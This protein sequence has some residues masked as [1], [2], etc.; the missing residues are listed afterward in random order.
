[1]TMDRANARP[2][3]TSRDLAYQTNDVR[4]GGLM[5]LRAGVLTGTSERRRKQ[6]NLRRRQ[7]VE[8]APQTVGREARAGKLD[9]GEYP[10]RRRRGVLGMAVMA[11][12]T[13]RLVRY[14]GRERSALS[15]YV[16][17]AYGR[18]SAY[19]TEAGLKYYR[20]GVVGSARRLYGCVR[21]YGELGTMERKE[22][23]LRGPLATGLGDRASS[24]DGRGSLRSRGACRGGIW[25]RTS[26]LRIKMGAVPMHRWVADV[27]EGAPSGSGLYFAVMG[28]V[29]MRR[30]LIRLATLW[31]WSDGDGS[32]RGRHPQAPMERICGRTMAVGGRVAMVQYRWKRRLA[33]SG[34]RNVGQ[35]R[36][37]LLV[38]TIDG[39]VGVRVYR[40]IY[41]RMTRM[42]WIARRSLQVSR[43]EVKYRTERTGLG[44]ENARRG[45]TR[46]RRAMSRAGVPPRGGFRG[47]RR[48]YREAV[49]QGYV[50]RALLGV[51]SGVVGAFNYLRMVKVSRFDEKTAGLRTSSLLEADR[52]KEEGMR[53]GTRRVTRRR[54]LLQPMGLRERSRSL[55]GER[56]A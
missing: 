14:R 43:R 18:G 5:R 10:L 4:K 44:Y 52:T 45:G 39:T 7:R 15:M 56:L 55:A 49:E 11:R 35:R 42:A 16:L 51:V 54:R 2:R 40:R 24:H 36:R 37:G 26:A 48:V 23:Q 8:E 20:V 13:D 31:H 53:L 34:I 22:M 38:G 41:R 1:M 28:K 50:R 30:V 19:S 9:G 6:R 27:Y 3:E 12:A 21:R 33:Y 32:W 17:A 29:P 46:R 25:R 47:K